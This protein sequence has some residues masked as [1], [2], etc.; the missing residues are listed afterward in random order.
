MTTF[1]YLIVN[2]K[3]RGAETLCRQSYKKDK[4]IIKKVNDNIKL[5]GR[6]LS[7]LKFSSA[8]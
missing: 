4:K 6:Y 2:F 7:S 1:S 3:S 5:V 8:W